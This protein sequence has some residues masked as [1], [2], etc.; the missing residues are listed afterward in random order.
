[1]TEYEMHRSGVTRGRVSGSL[2]V[3]R[4]GDTIEAPDGEMDHL[5]DSMYSTRVVESQSNDPQPT[6][7]ATV[8]DGYEIV[9]AGGWTKALGP[10]EEQLGN[11]IRGTDNEAYAT[12]LARIDTHAT[13]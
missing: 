2:H 12:A 1:M 10:D 4:A 5:R 6:A 7:Q 3:W 13:A 8:R 11:A 9:Q